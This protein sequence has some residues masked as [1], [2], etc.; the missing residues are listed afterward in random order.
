MQQFTP[1]LVSPINNSLGCVLKMAL[2]LSFHQLN[3]VCKKST[4]NPFNES[5]RVDEAYYL[6]RMR[7][8][9]SNMGSIIECS[10][11]YILQNVGS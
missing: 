11:V 9:S 6:E 4:A 8:N 3:G 1:L 5:E 7:T 2:V 10:S